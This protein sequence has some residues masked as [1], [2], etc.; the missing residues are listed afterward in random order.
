MSNETDI[1]MPKFEL[2]DVPTLRKL[3][4]TGMSWEAKSDADITSKMFAGFIAST[5]KQLADN[6]EAIDAPK[7]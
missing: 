6:I 1:K 5:C 3:E 4:Q 2:S 7:E